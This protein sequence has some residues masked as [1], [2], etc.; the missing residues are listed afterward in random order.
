[1]DAFVFSPRFAIPGATE[2][3]GG[4]TFFGPPS[5]L[6]R[7]GSELV[8]ELG[9]EGGAFSR[10]TYDK[11]SGTLKLES[12]ITGQ[13]ALRYA[14]MDGHVIVSSHDVLLAP[15]LAYEPDEASLAAIARFG[16][17]VG[18]HA[19]VRNITVCRG[20][21][22]VLIERDGRVTVTPAQFPQ[23]G[24]TVQSMLDYLGSRLPSGPIT[25]ELSAGWDSR[26]ALAATLACKSASDIR[27][28][29][30]GPEESLDVCIAKD[31]CKTLGVS[32]TRRETKMRPPAD[33]LRDWTASAW[34]NNGNIEIDVLASRH[35]TEGSVVCGDGGEI[36]RGNYYPYVPF[37]RLVKL[38]QY[39]PEQTLARKFGASERLSE[40]VN[41]LSA[42]GVSSAEVLD[43]FYVAE[44]YGIWNQKLAREA[45]TRISPFEARASMVEL[46]KG[47]QC[48]AHISLIRKHMPFAMQVPINGQAKP[49]DYA[50]GFARDFIL[51]SRVFAGK[52]Q[53]RVT[54]RT[55]LADSRASVVSETLRALPN[56]FLAGEARS[57]AE[58]GAQRFLKLFSE[59]SRKGVR[60]LPEV[61]SQLSSS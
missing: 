15:F 51:E 4:A 58:Y 36:H 45:S 22:S 14:F 35:R 17:S 44:R 13:L 49:S 21:E 52:V 55:N 6:K 27:V 16:W 2:E 5:L 40:T 28:F 9:S 43:R 10:L 7:Q 24:D 18:G 61:M 20:G 48:N 30:E 31:L 53:N 26:A 39:S 11:P 56:Q 47:E 59:V 1:M 33:I 38:Q 60:P 57:W 12:D 23:G 25:V 29:S 19:L 32:F 54:R 42:D 41:R 37:G 34:R 3:S 50:G 46:G 8:V